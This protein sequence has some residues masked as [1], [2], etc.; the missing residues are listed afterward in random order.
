MTAPGVAND[1]EFRNKFA[2]YE[3]LS[4]SPGAA[5]DLY[6]WV[7]SLDVR[8]V[9]PSISCPVLILHRRS[10]MH[11][12]F[13]YAEYLNQA[14]KDSRLV[15]LDG[16]DCHPFFAADLKPILKEI[17]KFLS[18][19]EE[20]RQISRELATIMFTDIV[21]STR[22]AASLGDH[23]WVETLE[24]HNSLVRSILQHHRGKEVE[25]TGD[26]FLITFDGPARAIQCAK[27]IR[28]KLEALNLQLRIGLHTGELEYHS[29]GASGIALHLA[30][31]IM[32]TASK[33]EICVSRT[34]KDL[35]IGSGIQFE[36]KGEYQ[37]KGIPD[38]WQLFSVSA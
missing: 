15:A 7:M 32:S 27:N 33:G 28:D 24:V 21:D 14:I 5:T 16:A 13:K 25:T 38:K 10:N 23:K 31:R 6:R 26:G 35:V 2:R 36:E 34:V 8:S 20:S 4:L 30:S 22:Q 1:K 29:E 12:Q 37:L 19:G 18:V 9:L 11:Y 17:R 3:R